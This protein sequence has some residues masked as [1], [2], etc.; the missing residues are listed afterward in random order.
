MNLLLAIG[1]LIV[2]ALALLQ[3]GP[4]AND[5]RKEKLAISESIERDSIA[6]M[7]AAEADRKDSRRNLPNYSL[8]LLL[9]SVLSE[10]S[11]IILIER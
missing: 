9:S 1:S 7:I 3:Y 5:L 4:I 6:P 11:V 2:L 10:V 8:V